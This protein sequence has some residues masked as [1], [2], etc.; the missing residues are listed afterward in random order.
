MKSLIISGGSIEDYNFLKKLVDKH[1]FII[2][3]DSG[4][5]HMIK[6]NVKANLVVG[7]L[8]SIS[9][10]G[11]EFVK[12]SKINI[13]KYPAQKNKTDT[14]L[15][16]DYLMDMGVSDINLTGVIGSRL[17]HSLA[18][19]YLLK[20]LYDRDIKAKIINENNIAQYVSEKLVL[21]KRE[22][23]FVSIIPISLNGI[24]VSLD[25]FLYSLE[26]DF[27]EFGS[28][29]GISNEIVDRFGTVTIHKGEALILESK[30]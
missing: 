15:A 10:E 6:I 27:I 18:N 2:C 9:E 22:D 16:I 26:N 3:A 25:G 20:K 17:D 7:D 12:D 30:D 1:N 24:E 14:E 5:D 13:L 28:S 29:L 23:Y 8:D 11:L 21:E 4:L 19:I